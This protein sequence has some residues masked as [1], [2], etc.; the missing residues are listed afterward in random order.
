[1]SNFISMG[2]TQGKSGHKFKFKWNHGIYKIV[3][4]TK[5]QK[6]K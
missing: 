2:I 3:V 4:L 6:K 5:N 1:M